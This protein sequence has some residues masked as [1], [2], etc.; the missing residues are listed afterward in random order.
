MVRTIRR[1]YFGLFA[2]I[3]TMV[4]LCVMATSSGAAAGDTTR[5][6][7]ASDG[8]EGNNRAGGPFISADG[9]YVVFSSP[10]SNL[11]PGDTNHAPNGDLS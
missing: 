11:V 7:V 10:A 2:V 5:V 1:S 9:R 4:L 6:S 8:T 3:A